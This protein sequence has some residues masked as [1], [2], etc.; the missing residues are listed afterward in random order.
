M[1]QVCIVILTG[2]RQNDKGKVSYWQ[3]PADPLT[4]KTHTRS[5]WHWASIQF[6]LPQPFFENCNQKDVKR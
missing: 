2:N 4:L 5:L 6:L 3:I 1:C